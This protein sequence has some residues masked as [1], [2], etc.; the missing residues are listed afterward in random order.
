MPKLMINCNV[1]I[2]LLSLL[3]HYC[4]LHHSHLAKVDNKEENAFLQ[5]LC[6]T[7][8]GRQCKLE[9]HVFFFSE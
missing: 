2:G 3:Q 9:L 4:F 6:R 7:A 8:I 1:C 5:N